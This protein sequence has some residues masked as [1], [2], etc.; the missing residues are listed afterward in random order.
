MTDDLQG[1][2]AWAGALLAKL[3]PAARRTITLDVAWE[4]RRSQQARIAAQRNP[5]G[6]AYD[7]RKSRWENGGKK[8]RNKRGRTKRTSMF[9]KLRTARYLH[10]EANANGL[11]IGFAGRIARIARVHQFGEVEPVETGGPRY[12]YPM[13]K[14]LGLAAAEQEMIKNR[15]LFHLTR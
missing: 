3:A 13:R 7:P 9:V 1:V 14:L 8:L 15:L 5:D 10:I 12:R 6:S 2:E 4:L 11:A